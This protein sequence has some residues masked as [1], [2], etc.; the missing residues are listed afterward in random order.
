INGYAVAADAT[1][2][3]EGNQVHGAIAF[4][5][6]QHGQSVPVKIWRQGQAME[7]ALPVHVNQKDRLE[8]NQY[9]PPKYFV[10][11]GLVFT[12]LSRDYLTTFGQNWSAVAGIGLLYELFYKKNAEP[13]K[14][15][16]EPIMLSTVLSHPVNANMEIRGRVLVDA[17]NGHRIDSLED[18]IQ[19]LEEHDDSHH[20][21]EFGERLGFECL[22]RQDADSA[23]AAIMETYG[24]QKDR[25]L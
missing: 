11:A 14:A 25:W 15:R 18:V 19:A 17:I 7:I 6:A 13:E 8:G 2:L 10:Y 23:N 24:I 20:L 1:I 12:P 22:D 16:K 21:I 5:Q 9:E 3:Y 4:S